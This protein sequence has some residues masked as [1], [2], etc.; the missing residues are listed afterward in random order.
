V[1]LVTS[2]G[3]IA[4][5]IALL[6]DFAYYLRPRELTSLRV[7]QLV[8]PL[9]FG[10]SARPWWSLLL[11]PEEH[12]TPSKTGYFDE[13]IRI[14]PT[15]LSWIGPFLNILIN[16]RSTDE[17]LWPFS[18]EELISSLKRASATLGLEHMEICLYSLR[19]GG[20]SHDSL[21]DLRTLMDIKTRGRWASD[22]SL[23]RYR[24]ETRAQAELLKLP[25][26]VR[27]FGQA[28]LNQ[29][30]DI[31]LDPLIARRLLPLLHA[32]PT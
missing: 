15:W 17:P 23:R 13:G 20:A 26:D 2:Q 22:R 4:E 30:D 29:I 31:F 11:H 21:H 28:T 6:P 32:R 27:T 1:G 3:Q 19:H 5:V 7:D 10:H 16:N 18:H 14:D 12:Q 9:P 8:A 24:K 25:D